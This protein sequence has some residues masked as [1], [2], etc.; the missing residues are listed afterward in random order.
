MD[1]E[2]SEKINIDDTLYHL[3]RDRCKKSLSYFIKKAWHIVEPGS[4]YVHGWHIDLIC[5]HLEAISDE[6]EIDGA[7]YNRLLINVPPGMM[8]SLLV[9]VF[10]PAWEWGPKNKPSM[11]YLMVS[12][13]LSNPVRDAGKLRR[14]LAS[15]WYQERWPIAF[16]DDQN[17]K[18]YYENTSTGFVAAV[19]SGSIT[20]KRGDRIFLDDAMSWEDA[21]SET[22]R[23]SRI[24][25][26]KGALPSRLNS[27]VRSSIIVIE[28]RLHQEDISGVILDEQLGYD[29]I[30]LPMEYDE[31]NPMN[32]T[33]LGIVDPRSEPGELLFPARFPSDT[34][35]RDKKVMSAYEVAGQY[36][37][38][39]VPKGGGI[40]DRLWWMPWNDEKYPE[41]DYILASLDT[42]YGEKQENDFSAMTIWGVYT[43]SNMAT[44]A[45]TRT[46]DRYGKPQEVERVYAEGAPHVIMMYAWRARLP[47]HELVQR[48]LKTCKDWKIDRLIV[49]GKAAGKSVV[50]EVRRVTSGEEYGI[51]EIDPGRSDKWQRLHSV[52]HLWQEGMIHAPDKEWAEMVIQEVEVFPKG[53]HDDLTD[54]VSQAAKFLRD[55]GLL[56]RAPERLQE[57]ADSMVFHGS[58]PR[59]LYPG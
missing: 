24:A 47:F 32:P 48:V 46:L 11:R 39:P 17:A 31:A 38:I 25:W 42:A 10:F 45:P 16:R 14:L 23:A 6:L 43:L 27:V 41:L 51:Q 21:N 54:T 9:N 7:L 50:Q 8:K 2:L 22:I 36:Q 3:E 33:L 5:L 56:T 1:M 26:F 55:S 20:G 18:T 30:K 34:L 13:S 19:A 15:E 28:Q 49:E 12:H 53:K 59:A 37:Q 44:M 40:I 4:D 29:H 58:A 52:S 35:A 57:I